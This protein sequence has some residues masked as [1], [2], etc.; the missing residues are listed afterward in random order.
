[1]RGRS[2]GGAHFPEGRGAAPI[3]GAW[4]SMVARLFR[5]QEAV[6]SNPAAPTNTG[7]PPERSAITGY[8]AAW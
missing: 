3:N 7:P 4:R 1:M 8:S 5:E 2:L 6:G